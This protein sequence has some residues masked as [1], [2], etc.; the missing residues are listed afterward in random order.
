MAG[1][2]TIIA[3][4]VPCLLNAFPGW[5]LPTHIRA[6]A[7]I[8]TG[9]IT[10][11]TETP[12]TPGVLITTAGSGVFAL[13]FPACKNIGAASGNVAPTTPGTP[14]NFRQVVFAVQNPTAAGAGSLTFR[15]IE[16]DTATS[17]ADPENGS[18]ID[19]NCWL[20]LG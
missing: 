3:Q 7:T 14:A 16:N 18:T 20:D 1:A 13:T 11:S 6:V 8:T 15:T 10:M 5:R 2:P 4:A 12:P 9:V 19:I 17:A